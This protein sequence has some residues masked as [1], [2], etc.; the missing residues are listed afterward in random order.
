MAEAPDKEKLI[1]DAWQRWREADFTWEGL[2]KWRWV[3]W[4]IISEGN[5]EYAVEIETG[6][7]YGEPKQSADRPTTAGISRP[8]SLQ[9]YWRADTSS[10]LLRTDAEMGPELVSTSR[11]PTYHAAHLPI[12]YEHGTS[13]L[14]DGDTDGQKAAAL[15]QLVLQRLKVPDAE[16]RFDGGVWL[17]APDFGFD[18]SE[19]ESISYR[20]AI[21]TGRARFVDAI[22]TGRA[23]FDDVTFTDGVWFGNATFTDGAWFGGATFINNAW[24]GGA[25][26]TGAWFSTATFEGDAQFD[27]AIFTHTAWFKYA[28]F[29]GPA[30]FSDA[31][32]TGGALFSGAT[33]KDIIRFEQTQ[34]NLKASFTSMPTANWPDKALAWHSAF[35]GAA[36]KCVLDFT[37]SGF[38]HL[39]VFDGAL[40]DV[41]IRLDGVAE[42]GAAET[43]RKERDAAKNVVQREGQSKEEHRKQADKQLA[44]LERG[45]RVLK[46]EMEKQSDKQREQM[47]YKF[48]L[49]ARRAQSNLRLG[50]KTFSFLYDWAADYGAS[51]I[52]P[53]IA[54]A[55][56]ILSFAG[57]FVGWAFWMGVA[58]EGQRRIALEPATIQAV[59]FSLSNSFKPLSAL[60]EDAGT[61]GTII[62]GL[63]HQNGWIGIC[64]RLVSI[65][66]SLLSVTLAFLFGLS[67]RR[68]FQ[69][70]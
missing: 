48:E 50:E 44:Q 58:G 54:L 55:I 28:T 24:F 27:H 16:A 70:N 18:K 36:F 63:L 9:D 51:I 7:K 41:G 25:T 37:G 2:A 60:A 65:L 33:F 22:F 21:F 67:V 62:D 66:Q 64:V 52:R 39:A 3:G 47:L 43:F 35:N 30:L 46:Q 4:L 49:L 13:T 38:G 59:N 53:F 68:R 29:T 40:I 31:N 8:A 26:F 11:Q 12:K 61:T 1:A 45:C 14:K 23:W 57:I 15:N 56:V 10:G 19:F 42:V 5:R 34:F 69:I 20:S 6:R 17:G 32:F